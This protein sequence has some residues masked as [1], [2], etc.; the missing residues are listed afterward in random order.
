ML[1][2]F[3]GFPAVWWFLVLSGRYEMSAP[4]FASDDS[5]PWFARI[6]RYTALIVW[7]VF[8][9]GLLL[10]MAW[11]RIHGRNEP[12]APGKRSSRTPASSTARTSST[13]SRT[14]KRTG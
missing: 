10:M 12:P 13:R 4:F 2:I 11:E 3:L 14:R 6:F 9:L 8:S 5:S 7:S 1:P